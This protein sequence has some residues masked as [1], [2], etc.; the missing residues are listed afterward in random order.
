MKSFVVMR[1]RRGRKTRGATGSNRNA[2]LMDGLLETLSNA[3][4]FGVAMVRVTVLFVL[5][6]GRVGG[7]KEAVARFG[8]PVAASVMGLEMAP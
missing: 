1:L 4:V 6:G 7:L 3:A 5:P 2:Q 8:R